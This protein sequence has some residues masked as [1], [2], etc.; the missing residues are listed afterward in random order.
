MITAKRIQQLNEIY[1][2][3]IFS[4]FFCFEIFLA[5][6]TTLCHY[7]KFSFFFFSFKTGKPNDDRALHA[8]GGDLGVER[9]SAVAEERQPQHCGQIG[10]LHRC[11]GEV[12]RAISGAPPHQRR[13]S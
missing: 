4:L 7:H 11:R 1:D 10:L 12:R 8:T 3:S 9:S 13:D 2:D 6:K 5:L